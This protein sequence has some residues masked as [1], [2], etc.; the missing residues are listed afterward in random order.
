[1]GTARLGGQMSVLM[2]GSSSE[3]VWICLQWWLPDV[4][5]RGAGVGPMSDVCVLGGCTV[6]SN[7][8]WVMA[9]WRPPPPMDGRTD[10]RTDKNENITF[11]QLR[12]RAVK[13]YVK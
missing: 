6:R 13:I 3:Q 4:T 5:G 12:W 8:S 1:M 9:T 11:P 2:G 10:W 7:A